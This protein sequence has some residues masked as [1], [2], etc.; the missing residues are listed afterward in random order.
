MAKDDETFSSGVCTRS[1]SRVCIN[2][3]SWAV[4]AA[5]ALPERRQIL[6]PVEEQL[7]AFGR[8]QVFIRAALRDEDFSALRQ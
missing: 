2:S 8:V 5:K 7:D 6:R 4:C 3:C 1:A